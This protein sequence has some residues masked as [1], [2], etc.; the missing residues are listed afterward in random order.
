MTEIGWWLA[1]NRSTR[2]KTIMP[3]IS[4]ATPMLFRKVSSRTPNELMTVDT[5]SARIARNDHMFRKPIGLG[6]EEVDAP[7]RMT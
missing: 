7:Q 3:R 1:K 5:T 6:D 4:A 2:A